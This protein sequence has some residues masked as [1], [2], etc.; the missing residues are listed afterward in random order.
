MSIK[1]KLVVAGT[2]EVGC[3]VMRG[4]F[5]ECDVTDL[6]AADISMYGDVEVRMPH[7][8]VGQHWL[9]VARER[10]RAGEA[11]DVVLRDYGYRYVLGDE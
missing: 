1:G 8:A 5:V 3:E 6:A 4:V 10:V 9:E 2:M 7:R 11:E